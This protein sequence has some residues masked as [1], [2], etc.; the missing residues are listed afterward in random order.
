MSSFGDWIG[1]EFTR[2]GINF[3]CWTQNKQFQ[4]LDKIS[5]LIENTFRDK[6]DSPDLRFGKRKMIIKNDGINEYDQLLI[7]KTSSDGCANVLCG[8]GNYT[9]QCMDGGCHYV[10]SYKDSSCLVTSNCVENIGGISKSCD[11]WC[12]HSGTESCTDSAN[13][14]DMK[15]DNSQ[16]N[17]GC[18]DSGNCQ[19]MA[20]NNKE[21]ISCSD[22]NGCKDQACCDRTC[23]DMGGLT[24]KCHDEVCGNGH[25]CGDQGVSEVNN[26]WDQACLN[27][28]TPGGDSC[29]DSICRDKP[30][31]NYNQCRDTEYCHDQTCRNPGCG[32]NDISSCIDKSCPDD[33][34]CTNG[35]T[36]NITR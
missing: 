30:C 25:I 19:D 6:S 9:I 18:L 34:I 13:C 3:S 5:E 23:N 20:C 4:F 35:G 10:T 7:P 27:S 31:V 11:N 8:T 22:S 21:A 16:S 14:V 12:N 33:P 15:C 36:C 29:G 2:Y 32:D 17:Y 1:V 24:G 28:G 26:C